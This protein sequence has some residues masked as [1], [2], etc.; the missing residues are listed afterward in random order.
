MPVFWSVNK[1]IRT[2]TVFHIIIC[3]KH[4]TSTRAT[5]PWAAKIWPRR[6]I[7]GP[8]PVTR[9]RRAPC[10]FCRSGVRGPRFAGHCPASK[11]LRQRAGFSRR[12]RVRQRM[13]RRPRFAVRQR[14]RFRTRAVPVTPYAVRAGRYVWH[15]A[16]AAGR[17]MINCE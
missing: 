17:G 4:G 16:R 12:L 5:A 11:L 9:Y 10:R 2:D 13:V 15:G 3:A 7:F 1:L 14:I 8:V 6:A